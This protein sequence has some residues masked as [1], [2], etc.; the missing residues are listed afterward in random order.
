MGWKSIKAEKEG[1]GGFGGGRGGRTRITLI[2]QF[3]LPTEGE[4]EG[5]GV[6]WGRLIERGEDG[7]KDK[8]GEGWGGG[9]IYD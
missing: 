5:S 7:E 8:E 2:Q 6:E 3:P 9:L 4:S 1:E